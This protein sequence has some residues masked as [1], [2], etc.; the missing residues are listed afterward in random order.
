MH[1]IRKIKVMSLTMWSD[2]R[3]YKRMYELMSVVRV[4]NGAKEE[5]CQRA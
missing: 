5:N 2:M 1:N 4:P 3:T